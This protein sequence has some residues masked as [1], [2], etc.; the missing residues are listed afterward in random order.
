[1]GLNWIRSNIEPI[2]SLDATTLMGRPWQMLV[3]PNV[4]LEPSWHYVLFTTDQER[5][6]YCRGVLETVRSGG[7]WSGWRCGTFAR[8]RT[9]G[10]P[11]RANAGP[12]ERERTGKSE[13]LECVWRLQGLRVNISE[14]NA[15]IWW[16]ILL[17]TI[18]PHQCLEKS[19][20]RSW[21]VFCTLFVVIYIGQQFFVFVKNTMC[22]LHRPLYSLT[23]WYKTLWKSKVRLYL[24]IYMNE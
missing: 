12:G 17:G 9:A 22:L 11:S 1:M 2:I 8:T 15:S 7:W 16:L 18:G 4:P 13:G 10:W 19:N 20:Y 24:Y 6:Y 3:W 5:I 21:V 23:Y 14:G